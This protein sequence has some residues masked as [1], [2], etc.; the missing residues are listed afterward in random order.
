M[1]LATSL[2]TV[3]LA[4]A[5]LV[6]MPGCSKK[7]GPAEHVGKEMDKGVAK[8]GEKIEKAG[9]SIQESMQGEKVAPVVPAV[10]VVPVVPLEKK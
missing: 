9:A 4:S 2:C 6:V 8:V 1:K 7:E 5:A 10:P 3:L